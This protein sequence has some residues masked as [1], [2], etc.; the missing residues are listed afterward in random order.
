MKWITLFCILITLSLTQGQTY[1]NGWAVGFGLSSPRVFGDVYAESIDFGG[2]FYLQKDVDEANSFRAKLDYLFFTSRGTITSLTS[3]P[4]N[5]TISLSLDYLYNFAQCNI[6]H[7]YGGTGISALYFTLTNPSSNVS[8]KSPVSYTGEFSVDFIF[9]GTYPVFPDLLLRTEVSLHQLTTD[10][11]DGEKGPA[12][13][14]FGGTLD[15][16]LAAELGWLWYLDRGPV[17]HDCSQGDG[18]STSKQP[19]SDGTPGNNGTD[20]AKIEDL[21]KKYSHQ[22]NDVDYNKIEDIVKR[23]SPV[24]GFNNDSKNAAGVVSNSRSSWV[25]IGINFDGS[26]ATFRP[27]AYPLLINAA[28]ILLTNPTLKIQIEGHTDNVGSVASNQRL[29]ETRA[30]EVKRFLISKG[31]DESRL[32]T[33]GFGATKPI[34][35]NKSAQGKA[36]NRRIEFKIVE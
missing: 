17:V 13:G 22:P 10:R 7:F 32:S 9:G 36:F 21:F 15:S 12:G 16:Y 26:K 35:D 24:M 18:L 5:K 20:Y 34:S 11:F 33:V 6:I 30:L 25:L 31:V 2:H 28:Q 3:R 19:N 8:A 27:E 29:S 14:L 4:S 23:N 1:Q